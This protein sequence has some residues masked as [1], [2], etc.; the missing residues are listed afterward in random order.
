MSPKLKV[1]PYWLAITLVLAAS[2]AEAQS[3]TNAGTLTCTTSETPPQALAD[4]ELSCGFVGHSGLDS[5]LS[6]TI[7]RIGEADI[8]PGKR[9]LIW[10][11]QTKIGEV[12]LGDLAGEYRGNTGGQPAGR[13]T[14]GK[15]NA[16][17]L[18][19]VDRTVKS[20]NGPVPTVLELRLK[21]VRA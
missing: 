13:L 21:E 16:I 4:A 18:D 12:Q 6:G 11:V 3:L 17:I 2:S 5:R 19:P 10:S 8:A 15:A 14:G 20:G 1:F 9:V 7:S